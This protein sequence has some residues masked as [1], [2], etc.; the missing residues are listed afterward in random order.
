MDI[1]FVPFEDIDITRW[2][3]C[4]HF[5]INGN[6]FGY[7]WFLKNV[8]REFDALV[9]GEYESVMPLLKGQSRWNYPTLIHPREIGRLGIFSVHVLSPA[10]IQKFLQAIPDHFLG[11]D[12]L[13][14]EF[15]QA[16]L[17]QMEEATPSSLHELDLSKPY[18][19]IRES[20]DTG[21]IEQIEKSRAQNWLP[22]SQIKPE[23]LVRFFSS[24]DP[25]TD[26]HMWMRIHYN[27]M[28]RGTAF[29]TV[30]AQ[31]DGSISAA[32][33][34]AYSNGFFTLLNYKAEDSKA[35]SLFYHMMDDL[36][37]LHADRSLKLDFNIF[38]EKFQVGGLGAIN[39]KTYR[40]RQVPKWGRIVRHWL[41]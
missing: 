25:N 28:H 26:T 29:P 3:S 15:N 24:I 31:S 22:H 38:G 30:Y 32:A 5:A 37:R 8:A 21:V 35:Q 7:H 36:I 39:K 27:L 40:L 19:I 33:L 18:E 23:E 13:F 14:N 11:R 6:V 16:H 4:I 9:E 2:N 1:R 20:Y 34:F 17:K 10:R 41:T 12:I